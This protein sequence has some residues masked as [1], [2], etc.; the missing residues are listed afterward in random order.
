ML[1]KPSHF[2][3]YVRKWIERGRGTWWNFSRAFRASLRVERRDISDRHMGVFSVSSGINLPGT[4]KK[5]FQLLISVE[6]GGMEEG[7]LAHTKQFFC[8]L[9]VKSREC[10]GRG[11]HRSAAPL[12]W[13]RALSHLPP[14]QTRWAS[15]LA[16]AHFLGVRRVKPWAERT[17]DLSAKC[18][19]SGEMSCSPERKVAAVDQAFEGIFAKAQGVH[20]VDLFLILVVDICFLFFIRIEGFGDSYTRSGVCKVFDWWATMAQGAGTSSRWM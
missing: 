16:Q 8:A 20:N 14:D 5:T 11:C 10:S 17:Q 15:R 12:Q 18:Q 9:E 3:S 13:E 19:W 6:G 2:Y 7:E 4:T 1:S